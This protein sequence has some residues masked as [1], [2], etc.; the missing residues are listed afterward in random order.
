MEHLWT[1]AAH[2]WYGLILKYPQWETFCHLIRKKSNVVHHSW[3]IVGQ[4]CSNFE[5]N[6]IKNQRLFKRVHFGKKS[7][8]WCEFHDFRR[9]FHNFFKILFPKI[10]VH[11]VPF[12]TRY[13]TLKSVEKWAIWSQTQC[14]IQQN[15]KMAPIFE[16]SC[17]FLAF[18]ANLIM[19][20]LFSWG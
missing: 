2:T 19:Y 13:S 9:F 10:K 1:D 7:S 12:P 17:P 4:L 11:N 16:F 6:Q 8:F 15:W 18:F 5:M 14:H 3:D 20:I